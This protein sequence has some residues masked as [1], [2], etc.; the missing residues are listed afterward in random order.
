MYPVETAI[1]GPKL[2][3]SY[4]LCHLEQKLG[5]LP[6]NKQQELKALIVN[7]SSVF[8]DVAGMTT[9]V[10]HDVDVGDAQPIKQHPYRVN[11][12]KLKVSGVYVRK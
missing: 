4:V 11:P 12:T 2:S 10:A 3:N 1:K 5:H 7:F 8:T 6:E 9:C